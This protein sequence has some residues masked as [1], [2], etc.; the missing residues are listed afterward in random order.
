MAGRKLAL[1]GALPARAKGGLLVAAQTCEGQKGQEDV[2]E[3]DVERHR[4]ADVVALTAVNDGAGLERDH[5]GADAQEHGGCGHGTRADFHKNVLPALKK[6]YVEN[7][8]EYEEFC[9]LVLNEK[10]Y[11]ETKKKQFKKCVMS[12]KYFD[13]LRCHYQ[14]QYPLDIACIHLS[15]LDHL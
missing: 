8:D 3:H 9:E 5:E 7:D 13:D 6:D 11:D 2:V 15:Y 1:A 14:S 4:R 12:I 10:N